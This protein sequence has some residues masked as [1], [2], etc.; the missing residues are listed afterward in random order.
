MEVRCCERHILEWS[1]VGLLIVVLVVIDCVGVLDC[2]ARAAVCTHAG[3]SGFHRCE[4]YSNLT[5]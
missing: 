2:V 3:Y 4:C 5:I 1:S